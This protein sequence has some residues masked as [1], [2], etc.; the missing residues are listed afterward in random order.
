MLAATLRPA[1]GI[2]SVPFPVVPVLS[3]GRTGNFMMGVDRDSDATLLGSK[4]GRESQSV[5][6]AAQQYA[7]A[8]GLAVR[9]LAGRSDRDALLHAER[10]PQ[11]LTLPAC[12]AV[13]GGLLA[14]ADSGPRYPEGEAPRP[15]CSRQRIAAKALPVCARTIGVYSNQREELLHHAKTLVA[16]SRPPHSADRC[17]TPSPDQ[18]GDPAL[19]PG[20]RAGFR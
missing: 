7:A 11:P 14:N 2:D 9:D 17:P 20:S 18:S 6:P 8:P 5:T 16:T 15:A 3:K 13:R 4:I 12:I 10:P 1:G 19:Q